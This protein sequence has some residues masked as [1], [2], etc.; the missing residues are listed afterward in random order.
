MIEEVLNPTNCGVPDASN[1]Y[2][3]ILAHVK[4][5][6]SGRDTAEQAIIFSLVYT[7]YCGLKKRNIRT[8]QEAQNSKPQ[9]D[10][11]TRR[12]WSY[13]T[14]PVQ[15]AGYCEDAEGDLEDMQ[16][17]GR[18]ILREELDPLLIQSIKAV[19]AI[20]NDIKLKTDKIDGD[21]TTDKETHQTKMSVFKSDLRPFKLIVTKPLEKIAIATVILVGAG[22]FL[23]GLKL[24]A[25]SVIE[26]FVTSLEKL[27]KFLGS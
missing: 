3:L 18:R 12:A 11:E 23:A 13:I 8:I 14:N 27:I 21:L 17:E 4:T 9:K 26:F 7:Y 15:I 10:I 1:A 2:N 24:F 5:K 6:Y 19:G 16:K 25:P 22:I 20:C